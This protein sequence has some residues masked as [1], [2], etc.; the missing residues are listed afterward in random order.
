[1]PGLSTTT[2]EVPTNACWAIHGR[3]GSGIV[4]DLQARTTTDVTVV[5]RTNVNGS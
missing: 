3:F 5:A 2:F 4:L 1:M